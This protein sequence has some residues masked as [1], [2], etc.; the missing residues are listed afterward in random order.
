MG[1]EG[2]GHT[3]P[4]TRKQRGTLLL[5]WLPHLVHLNALMNF[6]PVCR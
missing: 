5:T 2:P 6:Y 1:M 3:A 4:E